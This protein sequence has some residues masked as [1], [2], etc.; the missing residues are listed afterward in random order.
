MGI[1]GRVEVLLAVLFIALVAAVGFA[2]HALLRKRRHEREV[3]REKLDGV[4]AGHREMADQHAGSLEQLRPLA[5]AH[6]QAA[7][8]HT[9]TAE[10]IEQR[11]ERQR[12]HARF[13]EERAAAT[14]QRREQV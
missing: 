1:P 8:D 10:E 3:R 12:R 14:Q 9:R 11:I 6:R 4:V 13:H 7:V 2:V 5:L